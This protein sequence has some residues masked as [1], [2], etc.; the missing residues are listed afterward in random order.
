MA[1]GDISQQ[2]NSITLTSH[3]DEQHHKLHNT[4]ISG[5]QRSELWNIVGIHITYCTAYFSP[6]L[7]SYEALTP[8]QLSL[9]VLISC[10]PIR[11]WWAAVATGC[12]PNGTL[13]HVVQ[14]FWLGP[15]GSGQK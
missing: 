3:S 10:S 2:T 14:Y 12:V 5:L 15:I 4:Y 1:F 7:S 11:L 9:S 8:V 13:I 6:V